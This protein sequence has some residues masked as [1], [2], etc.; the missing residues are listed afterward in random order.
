MT[1]APSFYRC[2]IL[3]FVIL[4]PYFAICWGIAF[5]FLGYGPDSIAGFALV[6][7]VCYFLYAPLG[8]AYAVWQF[9]FSIDCDGIRWSPVP[10]LISREIRIH[11]IKKVSSSIFM[12]SVSRGFW[13][14]IPIPALFLLSLENQ[15]RLIE[16]IRREVPA[17]NPLYAY[18]RVRSVQAA[19]PQ[20]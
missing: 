20:P 2:L 16:F 12:L 10:R 11:E 8:A 1:I 9:R 4:I 18:A 5:G 3:N 6:T 15:A 17:E 14:K 13:Y 7:L 19:K